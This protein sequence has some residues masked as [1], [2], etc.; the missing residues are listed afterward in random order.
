MPGFGLLTGTAENSYAGLPTLP[1]VNLTAEKAVTEPRQFALVSRPRLVSQAAVVVAGVTTYGL[2][3][4]VAIYGD[5][6]DAIDPE[7]NVYVN[8]VAEGNFLT[9]TATFLAGNE[10]GTVMCDN[11]LVKFWDGTTLRTVAIPDDELAVKVLE[12]QG[13]FI[14]IISEDGDGNVAQHYYWTEPLLNMI[15]GSGDI[16]IDALDF[17]S[18]ESSPDGLLDGV[19][20]NG[21]LVL[22]GHQ[23]IEIHTPSGNDDLPWQALVGSVI[24]KGLLATGT[25]TLWNDGFAWVDN[26]YAVHFSRGGGST[27]V[28][29]EGIEDALRDYTRGLLLDSFSL[30]GKEYLRARPVPPSGSFSAIN[31]PHLLLD[32][33]SGE[34]TKWSSEGGAFIGG[35]VR[36]SD[37]ENDDFFPLTFGSIENGQII[38]FEEAS[39]NFVEDPLVYEFRC[40]VPIDGGTITMHNIGLRCTTNDAGTISLRTSHDLGNTWTSW[41]DLTLT[42]TVRQKV[43]W[44]A[45]GSADAPGFLCDIK[46]ANI[47]EFYVSGAYFNEFI[48]GRGR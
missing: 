14:F 37:F 42:G 36:T 46:T 5:G 23:T 40:G 34:W 1:L 11:G 47:D 20:W 17:A 25:M 3:N 45:R 38:G 29:N 2:H 18:A 48:Q 43:E 21:N 31:L 22:G 27:R 6:G 16:D 15:D 10:V 19:I 39:S 30:G 26:Q 13:R 8:G 9:G 41:S 7:D 44:R 33:E 28:S 24:D 32:S 12:S 35:P 4:D